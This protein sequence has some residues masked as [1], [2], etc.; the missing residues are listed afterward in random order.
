MLFLTEL[1]T[2]IW[3]AAPDLSY[4]FHTTCKFMAVVISFIHLGLCLYLAYYTIFTELF[5]AAHCLIH[6][7]RCSKP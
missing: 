2:C 3:S 5:P 6:S 4:G 7:C 1:V